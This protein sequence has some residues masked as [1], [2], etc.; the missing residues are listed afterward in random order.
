M[1]PTDL[2][3]CQCGIP[4]AVQI[5]LV[6]RPC[7]LDVRIDAYPAAGLGIETIPKCKVL[8]EKVKIHC[9]VGEMNPEIYNKFEQK[10]VHKAVTLS[11]RRYVVN[12]MAISVQPNDV[13]RTPISCQGLYR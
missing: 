10:L 13:S 8:I 4:P 5:K 12:A 7:N 6:L 1:I 9:P 3:G 2:V 11:F